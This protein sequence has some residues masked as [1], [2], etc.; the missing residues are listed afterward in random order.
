MNAE[1][2][3]QVLLRPVVS[4]KSTNAAEANRQVVFEVLENAT[5]AEVREAVEKLFDVSVTA[6]Q[7]LNVRGKVKRFG[8]TPGKRN[9]WKKAYVRLAAGDDIDF[10][11]SGA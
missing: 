2:M 9:N 11:G 10:L 7:V 5:K 4:E 1:R 3:H 8:K 6:V